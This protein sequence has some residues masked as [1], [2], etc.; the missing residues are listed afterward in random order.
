M[1][2]LWLGGY[3]LTDGTHR[4][5]LHPDIPLRVG[6]ERPRSFLTCR[7]GHFS[8]PYLTEKW[9]RPGVYSFSQGAAV[10]FE[11]N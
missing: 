2:Y 5:F 4:P 1:K 11:I 10:L 3:L 6:S 7:E 8:N 9:N